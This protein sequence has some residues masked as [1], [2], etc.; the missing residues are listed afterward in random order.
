MTPQQQAAFDRLTAALATGEVK[1]P[2]PVLDDD[3]R[4]ALSMM[5]LYNGGLSVFAVAEVA[6]NWES[7][8]EMEEFVSDVRRSTLREC[9]D[10]LRMMSRALKS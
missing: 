10:L 2:P 1:L 3:L 9:A 7:M 5:R 4:C 8:A 6:D